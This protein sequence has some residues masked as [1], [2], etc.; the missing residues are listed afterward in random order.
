MSA[1]KALVSSTISLLKRLRGLSREEIIARCDA[2]KKQLEL[3]GM[4]L[5]REAEKFYKEAV[6]FAK[7]KM[8]KAAR[9]SLEAWSE[10]K[11]EAEACIHMARLYDRI[12]L[13]VTRI[14]SLR[15]MTKISE[16]VV[17]EFDKLLGQLPD[18]P[19]S[20]RYMLEGAI[21]TLDS[22]MAH[23]VESTAPPEV[24][25]EAEKELRAIMSGEAV[26][27]A[28]PLEEI[29]IGQEAL[30]REEVRT[31]EEEVSKELEKIKSMIGV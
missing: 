19:V 25:A 7:R 24:A 10:Y 15:D 8:L 18:D 4:S 23:Y 11:S 17:N 3:R 16:L 30:G 14:S 21:D 5:M 6:F 20:A 2:L 9:A 26:V 27:E 22:M 12:K 31:K 13:R 1:V 29:R 28:R